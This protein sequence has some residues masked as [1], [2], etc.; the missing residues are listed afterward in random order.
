MKSSISLKSASLKSASWIC[1]VA[2]LAL[3]PD[4]FAWQRMNEPA[5]YELHAARLNLTSQARVSAD[6]LQIIT[7]EGTVTNYQRD[8]RFDSGDRAWLGF[9]SAAANQVLRWPIHHSG[10]LQIGTIRGSTIEYRPSEMTIRALEPIQRSEPI[11]RTAQRPVV[12]PAQLSAAG[13]LLAELAMSKLFDSVSQSMTNRRSASAGMANAQMLRIASYD[14]RGTPWVLAR[15]GFDL[16]CISSGSAAG[17]DWWV[18]PAGAG[19][20]RV[21][22]YHQGRVYAVS[23]NRGGTL[24]LLPLTQDP[25][26]FWRVTGGGRV[27]NRFVLENVAYPGNCLSRTDRGRVALQPITYSPMQMWMPFN[28]PVVPTFEPFWRSGSTEVIANAPL[29]PAELEL[30]NTHRYALIVLLGDARKGPGFDQIRIEPG[31]SEIVALE[32]DSGSTIVETVE[33]RSAQGVWERQQYVTAVPPQA[34]YDL[35][36]YEEHLQSISLDATGPKIKVDDKNY[37]PKSVGWL[38]LPAGAE[39]PA[40]AQMDVY[41]RAKDANNP[42]AVRRMDP[43]Q[44]DAPAA[45]PLED[46][47]EKVETP[48]RRKF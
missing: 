21:E 24:S 25:Q 47:L 36:V 33:I 15:S 32:R 35:S 30:R 42:G 46:I 1:A 9:Y 20:V 39:L 26:Q 11:Q 4:A 3:G 16:T 5:Q 34:F 38:P 43:K 13:G 12:P 18:A 6:A 8:S 17:A 7:S 29:P 14:T 19:I 45:N 28:A 48:L 31:T 40:Q 37:V 2:C 22:T 10:N 41:S 44:F 23:A 27:A